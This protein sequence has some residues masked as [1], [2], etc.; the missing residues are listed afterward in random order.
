MLPGGTLPLLLLWW[1]VTLW[2]ISCATL[3]FA[4]YLELSPSITNIYYRMGADGKHHLYW[5]HLI[6]AYLWPFT[7]SWVWRPMFWDLNVLCHLVGWAVISGLVVF[8]G[9]LVAQPPI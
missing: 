2:V 3:G 6:Q 4:A 8:V 9:S 1:P 5:S 7:N